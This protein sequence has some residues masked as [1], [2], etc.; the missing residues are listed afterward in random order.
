M[1]EQLP[2]PGAEAPRGGSFPPARVLLADPAWSFQDALPGRKR[3]AVKNYQCMTLEQVK[4]FPLPPLADD[5]VLFLWRVA[6]MQRAALEVMEA[7]GFGEPKS[8]I[9]WEKTTKN[10][11]KHFGMGRYFRN[12]HEVCLIGVRGRYRKPLSSVRSSFEAPVTGHSSKPLVFYDIIESMYEGPY[13]ELFA[14]RH[15]LGWYSIGNQLRK[16]RRVA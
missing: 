8:E 10:G 3:G 2:I 13:V 14:R 5:C 9:V 11:K 1:G 7:W 12:T 4:T 16:G 15:R 6:S